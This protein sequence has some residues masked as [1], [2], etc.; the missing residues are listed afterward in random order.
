MKRSFY[1]FLLLSTPLFIFSGCPENR[2][3]TSKYEPVYIEREELENSIRTI[4]PKPIKVASKIVSL[5]SYILMVEQYKGIH[6]IDNTD[7]YNPIKKGYIVIPGV[8]D[9]AIKDNIIYANSATDLVSIDVTNYYDVKVIDRKT[10]FFEEPL[11]PDIS[12]N[13]RERLII[14]TRP[15][16]EAIILAWESKYDSDEEL[17]F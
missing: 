16:D 17:H 14:S 13:E 1:Y 2:E 8:K 10:D 4:G 9:I 11:P 3:L 15:S 5:N 12:A 6:I 7:I